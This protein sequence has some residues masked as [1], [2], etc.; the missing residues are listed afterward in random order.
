MVQPE[1]LEPLKNKLIEAANTGGMATGSSGEVPAGILS[2]LGDFIREDPFVNSA[3][4]DSLCAYLE[5]NGQAAM[6]FT[7]Q[8][9][10]DLK[11]LLVKFHGSSKAEKALQRLVEQYETEFFAEHLRTAHGSSKRKS[12]SPEAVYKFLMENKDALRAFGQGS[13]KEAVVYKDINAID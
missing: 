9:K 7:K 2:G 4:V 1:N 12:R 8:Q 10:A 3:K 11:E 6:R 5:K 13:D